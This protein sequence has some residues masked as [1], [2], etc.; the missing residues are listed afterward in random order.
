[1]IGSSGQQLGPACRRRTKRTR[2]SYHGNYYT[3]DPAINGNKAKKR[4]GDGGKRGEKKRKEDFFPPFDIFSM[5]H[6]AL[7]V[8]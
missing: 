1:M 5:I 3:A 4:E 2:H 6:G 8:L 7:K